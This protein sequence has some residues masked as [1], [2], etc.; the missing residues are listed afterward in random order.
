M[1]TR[2]GRLAAC[3]DVAWCEV[4]VCRPLQR[5]GPATQVLRGKQACQADICWR[6][7]LYV[8]SLA[9]SAA[10][11]GLGVPM[12]PPEMPFLR[13]LHSHFRRRRGDHESRYHRLPC[14]ACLP[15]VCVAGGDVRTPAWGNRK[16]L[17]ESVEIE[18]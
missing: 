10:R 13:A 2:E 11:T 4:R 15:M 8:K 1:P 16:P 5:R 6:D 18:R 14:S 9:R 12:R 7:L 3:L 17:T